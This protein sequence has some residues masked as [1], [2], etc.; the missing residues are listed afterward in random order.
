MIAAIEALPY[1][2]VAAIEG[3]CMGGGLELALGFDYRLASSHPKTELGLPEVKIGLFPGWGG[4]QR[5][6]RLIGPSLAAEMIC[7][8]EAAKAGRAQQ[9]GIVFDV[10][11]GERLLAEAVR[12]LNW[13]QESGEWRQA[14]RRKQQPLGLSEE[15]LSFAYAVA[16]AQVMEKTK[17]QLPAPLAALEAISKGCNLTLEEGLKIES[18]LFAP[19]VGSPISRNLIAV[20]FM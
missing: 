7:S 18:E 1:P 2:T 14:R 13:A 12:L 8:G 6:T 20:F 9:L 19:L 10:V 11:P 16:R 5:L 4:T 17:G 15:Q 3:A